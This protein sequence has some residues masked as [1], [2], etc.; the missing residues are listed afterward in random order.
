MR[1]REGSV[2]VAAV[3]GWPRAAR[4]PLRD[5]CRPDGVWS[6]DRYLGRQLPRSRSR[7]RRRAS[8]SDSSARLR[9]WYV[10]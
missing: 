7:A 6:S 4:W 1:G 5:Q 2:Q 10:S 3:A 9:A 8:S